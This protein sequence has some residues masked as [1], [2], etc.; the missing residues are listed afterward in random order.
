MRV[1][2]TGA[3][4]FV[5]RSVCRA[6]VQRGAVVTGLT[7]SASGAD[8]R[9]DRWVVGSLDHPHS[10]NRLVHEADALVHAAG[11]VRSSDEDA[12]TRT[13]VAGTEAV[14]RA[15]AGRVRR[16]VHVST[17]GVHGRPHRAA[18]EAAPL[19]PANP[20][21]R[22]KAQSE[23][24][25]SALPAGTWAV[26][27]PT[28]IVGVGHPFDPLVRFLRAVARSRLWVS[29]RAWTNYVGV[30]DVAAIVA[31]LALDD[32]GPEVVFANAPMPLPA[33]TRT[34]AG[35]LGVDRDGH[36]LPRPVVAA[37]RPLANR[38][39]RLGRMAALF[40]ETRFVT[41]HGGWLD[42]RLL[43]PEL[44]PTLV[45]MVENYRSRGLL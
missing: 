39:P 27:R 13:N 11:L 40:D 16:F 12:L 38:V 3:T 29:G 9:V 5:G 36:E 26:V 2:V 8:A 45:A 37:L 34:A 33:L 20:Y 31:E 35:I 42:E 14:V 21:E 28:D 6:L 22:S 24:I 1:A 44:R 15:A 18:D 43:Q 32:T 41:Q 25:V 23:S 17:A 19:R 30:D 4:G 10:L 7:R